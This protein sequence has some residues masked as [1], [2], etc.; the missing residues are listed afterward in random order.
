VAR[1]K[2]LAFAIAIDPGLPPAIRTDPQRLRQILNN[3]LVNAFKFTSQ[4]S[5]S[6]RMSSS[7]SGSIA[8]AV[9]DTGIGIPPGQHDLVFE[10]FRQADASASRRFGGTG[11]GLSISRELAR[12]LGGEVGLR[13]AESGGC[14]FTLRLPLDAA[15]PLQEATR[16]VAA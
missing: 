15:Q 3:L 7:A 16:S 9:A 12:M 13:A 14:I 8:F 2:A 4:G 5:V 11:L 6:L 1:D 10:A